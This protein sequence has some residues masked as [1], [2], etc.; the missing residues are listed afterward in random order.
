MP[1]GKTFY[2]NAIGLENSLRKQNDGYT[3]FGY[4]EENEY[5]N[6]NVNIKD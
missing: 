3:F 6:E 5:E 4:Q 1:Q 2:I